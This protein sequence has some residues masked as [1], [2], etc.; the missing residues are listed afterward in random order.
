MA[1]SSRKQYFSIHSIS[2]IDLDTGIP[3]EQVDVIGALTLTN[4]SDL[5]ENFGG[6]SPYAFA[7]EAGSKTTEGSMTVRELPSSI[8][9]TLLGAN[10]TVN[11][12]EAAGS[13]T[14]LAAYF[15]TGLVDGATGIA[16]VGL[17][18]GSSA[19]VK[20]VHYTVKAVSATTVDVYASSDVDFARGSAL[21][22]QD[23]SLKITAT[24][25]T[26]PGT[27]GVVEIPNTGLELTGGSGVVALTTDSTATFSSRPINT[28]SAI[29]NVGS[30]LDSL[31]NVG[32]VV[33]AKKRR[34]GEL[35]SLHM[36][37]VTFGGLP[38]NFT[39]NEYYNGDIPFKLSRSDKHNKKAW[40]F[41]HVDGV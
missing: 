40:E 8:F 26:V 33:E 18:S 5:I 37:N 28:G 16:S 14:A 19:D 4:S 39:E 10:T 34:T 3:I 25:L 22:Y 24:P 31:P 38:L 2:F 1:R 11:A 21:T 9:N 15:G 30:D 29:S 13:V 6:S 35:G 7:S 32:L 27:G 20:N 41:L 23:D 12:A 36:Y 17:K